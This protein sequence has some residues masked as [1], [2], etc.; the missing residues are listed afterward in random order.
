MELEQAIPN[1]QYRSNM[2]YGV[3]TWC[4]VYMVMDYMVYVYGG[5]LGGL[6]DCVRWY[7]SAGVSGMGHIGT[8]ISGESV[9][10]CWVSFWVALYV[11]FFFSS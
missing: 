4:M 1:K 5:L 3:R 11:P 8:T 7:E 6:L 2:V 10:G 9:P